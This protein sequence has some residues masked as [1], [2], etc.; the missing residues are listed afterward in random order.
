MAYQCLADDTELYTIMVFILS[1]R[2]TDKAKVQRGHAF[3]S[4]HMILLGESISW[5]P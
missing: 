3:E 4:F 5:G 1:S 2:S